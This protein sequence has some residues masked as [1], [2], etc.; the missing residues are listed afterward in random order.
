MG[1]SGEGWG[2][3]KGKINDVPRKRLPKL[4]QNSIRGVCEKESI[5]MIRACRANIFRGEKKELLSLQDSR[6]MFKGDLRPRRVEV[7]GP[8]LAAGIKRNPSRRG[9][10]QFE[11]ANHHNR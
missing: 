6:A 10:V 11:E 8:P 9:E 2:L 5:R 1:S 4:F 3:T 7:L